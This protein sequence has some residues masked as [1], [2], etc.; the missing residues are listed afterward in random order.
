MPTT[1]T[2]PKG[3]S[4]AAAVTGA[5]MV[6]EMVLEMRRLK[7]EVAR[8]KA[9]V[10]PPPPP[11]PPA[12]PWPFAPERGDVPSWFADGRELE[13]IQH[14]RHIADVDRRLEEMR[15]VGLHRDPIDER[16]L[17]RWGPVTM[18][19]LAAQDRE[20]KWYRALVN[21]LDERRPDREPARH[22][23]FPSCVGLPWRELTPSERYSA[24]VSGFK[25][26]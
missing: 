18:E 8:L 23:A 11:P 5:Q 16:P 3:K 6:D 25:H 7:E 12:D 4:P 19:S 13:R 20:P 21:D 17:W 9:Q 24:A 10:P 15:V 2:A 14:A 26:Q 1:K 22:G